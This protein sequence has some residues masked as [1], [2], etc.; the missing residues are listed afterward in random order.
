MV[1]CQ[2]QQLFLDGDGC[3]QKCSVL[4]VFCE[5][6]RK[7]VE[8]KVADDDATTLEHLKLM[9]SAL[10]ISKR[11]R[12]AINKKGAAR[13]AKKRKEQPEKEKYVRREVGCICLSHEAID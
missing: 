7:G 2:G 12:D 4:F 5:M 13:A 6:C 9:Q 10:E 1:Y 8:R 11:K 3:G